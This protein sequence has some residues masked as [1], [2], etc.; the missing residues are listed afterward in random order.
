MKDMEKIVGFVS[1]R[2]ARRA[3]KFRKD[4]SSLTPVVDRL[5]LN[6]FKRSNLG[7]PGGHVS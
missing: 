6:S 7:L 2:R 1:C 3:G 4:F 5:F